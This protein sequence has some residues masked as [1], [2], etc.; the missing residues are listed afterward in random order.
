MI[1]VNSTIP[2]IAN[3]SNDGRTVTIAPSRQRPHRIPTA[4]QVR[5]ILP[6]HST[7]R[8]AP[9]NAAS[10]AQAQSMPTRPR[11]A[12][13]LPPLLR[14][15]RRQRTAATTAGKHSALRFSKKTSPSLWPAAFA[16]NWKAAESP[17]LCCA[18]PTPLCPSTSAPLLPTPT[19]QPSTSRFTPPQP[20]TAFASIPRCFPMAAD[21]RGPFRSWTTSQHASLPLSQ[22][23]ATE[24]SGRITEAPD[25]CSHSGGAACALS[26]M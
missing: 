4:R 3:F 5:P 14:R 23:T 21:D 1:T 11:S 9:S 17:L 13:S 22:T 8:R 12:P 20:D 15:R 7:P 6:A 2:V 26:T 10:A 16:R 25:S 18:I 24:V 19:T